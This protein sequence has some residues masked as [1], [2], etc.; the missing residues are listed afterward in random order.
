GT[1]RARAPRSAGTGQRWPPTTTSGSWHVPSP[2]A[3]RRPVVLPIL[4][5]TLLKRLPG[6]ARRPALPAA[7]ELERKAEGAREV[8][9]RERLL[10]RA[11]RVDLP[12]AQEQQ[13]SEARRDLLDVVRHENEDR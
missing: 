6:R 4:C 10:D 2:G 12:V 5:H 11:G 3:Q 13:V 8:L 7:L 9:G 1:G